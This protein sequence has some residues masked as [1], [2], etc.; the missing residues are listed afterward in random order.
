M[1]IEQK[2]WE[3][4]KDWVVTKA[5]EGTESPQLVLVFGDRKALE[6]NK[7]YQEIKAMYPEARIVLCSTAGEI[8]GRTVSDNSI[9]LTAIHFE[10]TTFKLAETKVVDQNDSLKAG[11]I[12]AKELSSE[13][14][15][16][17]LVF[18]DGLLVNGTDLAIGLH[19]NLADNVSVTGGLVGDGAEFKKTVIGVDGVAEVGKIV[20]IGLYGNGIKVA[21]GSLGGWDTFGPSRTVT[22]VEGNVLFE[23][24]GLP[25]LDLYK[26][27]LGDKAAELPSSGLLF[28][29][30]LDIDG[31]EIVRTL[32][33]IDEEKKSMTFAGTIPTGVQAKLMK[34]NFDRLVYGAA[35]AAAMSTEIISK[36]QAELAILVSCIGRKLV[37][38]ERVEDE[39]DAVQ[40]TLGENVPMIGFY[41]Y[42]ELCPMAVSEKQC[43]L[44]NQT[45]TITTLLEE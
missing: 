8:L 35:G 11:E 27:Y 42:G 29:L 37:L 34:A 15:K 44:L 22:K 19:K 28:P 39:L 23:L 17:V 10:K 38:G 16:H 25:A 36:N 3:A 14:L 21:Y 43:K 41:S 40:S 31:K 24:D 13:D 26:E 9:A 4:G 7:T 20:A 18:S 5:F 6:E 32:L 2:K 30:G 1:K 45:M 33:A 12:L